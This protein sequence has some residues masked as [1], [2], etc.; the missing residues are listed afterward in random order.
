MRNFL[1]FPHYAVSGG[2]FLERHILRDRF[3]RAKLLY[4]V[5]EKSMDNAE[6]EDKL[7]FGEKMSQVAAI[8]RGLFDE[9]STTYSFTEIE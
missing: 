7:Y 4:P 2:T 6:K 9:N 3:Y 5:M 8:R 1:K